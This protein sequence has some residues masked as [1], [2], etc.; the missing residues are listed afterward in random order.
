MR[1]VL[2]C[3][4]NFSE[5]SN[6]RTLQ[7]LDGAAG[8]V[9]DAY[10]LDRHSDTDHN[11]S[12]YT[13]AGDPRA[14]VESAFRT[15]AA[16]VELIDLRSHEGVHP[17]IGAADVIPLVPVRGISP[18]DCVTLARTLGERIALELQVPVLLYG[19]AS[20]DRTL[21]PAHFR[22]SASEGLMQFLAQ[23]PPEFG[24]EIPHPTAG[25]TMVG[26]RDYLVA[27]NVTLD[28]DDI[29]HARAIAREVRESNG[30]LRGIQSLGFA[31]RSGTQ[32]STNLTDLA[33]TRLPQ[34]FGAIQ[35]A[36]AARN[37]AITGAELVGLM[38]ALALDGA[39]PSAVGLD[40]AVLERTLERKLS[41]LSW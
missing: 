23:H 17:R 26:A 11:R 36:A 28:T 32:V 38:P 29:E 30:G 16:A 9:E 33:H 15:V 25:A 10:L 20:P 14:V 7:A 4:P 21:R 2:E 40:E 12:V 35:A 27:Y 13:I 34:A 24:P 39:D 8:G 37:V 18:D 6:E 41:L 19:W 31:L 22:R 3:V 1:P 5:G